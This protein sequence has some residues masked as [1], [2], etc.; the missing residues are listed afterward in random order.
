MGFKGG[1]FCAENAG[2]EGGLKLDPLNEHLTAT[3]F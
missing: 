3:V 1:F 2:K